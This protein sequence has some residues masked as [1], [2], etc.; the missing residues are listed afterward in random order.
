ME[1]IDWV[2]EIHIVVGDLNSTN[3]VTEYGSQR[4]LE[5]AYIHQN[6]SANDIIK[7]LEKTRV[8]I[9][10]ASTIAL[11]VC[12]CRVPLIVGWVADNQKL[13]YDGLVSK[14]MA[15]GL[16]DLKSLHTANL[17]NA[18][19]EL[20]QPDKLIVGEMCFSQQKYLPGTSSKN[21]EFAF[22]ELL[23]DG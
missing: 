11:E 4:P 8:A 14:G 15:L 2:G 20:A 21:L 10:S 23:N 5:K 22:W 16:G 12:A 9:C 18:I 1:K 17:E 3:I 19:L 13:I 6:I 7:L